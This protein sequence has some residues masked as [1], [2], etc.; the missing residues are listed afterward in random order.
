MELYCIC[1]SHRTNYVKKKIHNTCVSYRNCREI[2]RIV[3]DS[4][5][6]ASAEYYKIIKT[7]NG[8]PKKQAK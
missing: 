7:Y 1:H 4:F 6:V 2:H 8:F 3:Y 5:D